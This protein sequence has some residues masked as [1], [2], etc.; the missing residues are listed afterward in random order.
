MQYCKYNDNLLGCK[1]HNLIF[2]TGTVSATVDKE[3]I[4]PEAR[5]II[6]F[7][8]D[9]GFERPIEIK[10]KAKTEAIEPIFQNP[11]KD[12]IVETGQGFNNNYNIDLQDYVRNSVLKDIEI[13]SPSTFA[14]P[15]E[16]EGLNGGADFSTVL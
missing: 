12:L 3:Q 14:P 9:S 15:E 8:K 4:T 6:D 7:F 1:K 2:S 13:N 16:I 5:Y 10:P 11:G